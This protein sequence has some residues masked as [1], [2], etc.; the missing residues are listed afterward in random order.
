[1]TI[2]LSCRKQPP[3][4]NSVSAFVSAASFYFKIGSVIVRHVEREPQK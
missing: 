4:N 1:M 2:R 3:R